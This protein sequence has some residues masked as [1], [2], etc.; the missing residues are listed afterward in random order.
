M[1]NIDVIRR[2]MQKWSDLRYL[3]SVCPKVQS[4]E[5]GKLCVMVQ[6]CMKNL[7]FIVYNIVL[8]IF[9]KYVIATE[10]SLTLYVHIFY[11]ML[12]ATH[13]II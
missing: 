13:V 10:L 6:I 11:A 3:Q 12:T 9:F 4:V 5:K 1:Q 7:Y 8:F 2:V